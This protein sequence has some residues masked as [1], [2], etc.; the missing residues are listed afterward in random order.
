MLAIAIILVPFEYI[1]TGDVKIL[2]TPNVFCEYCMECLYK[3][4]WD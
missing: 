1:I 4:L 2:K 3:K